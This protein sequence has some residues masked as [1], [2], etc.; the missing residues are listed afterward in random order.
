MFD[1]NDQDQVGETLW[2]KFN[3]SEDHIVPYSRDT[4]EHPI[5]SFDDCTKKQKSDTNTIARFTGQSSGAKNALSDASLENRSSHNAKED[6]SGPKIDMDQWPDLPALNNELSTG[7]LSS[8]NRSFPLAGGAVQLDGESEI[9]SNV[10]EQK[11]NDSFLDCDW[12]SIGDFDDLDRIFSN[13]S[14]FGHDMATN[15]DEFLSSSADIIGNTVLPIPMPDMPLRGDECSDHGCSSFQLVEHSGEKRKAGDKTA[16]TMEIREQAFRQTTDSNQLNEKDDRKQKLLKSRKKAEERS[17]NKASEILYGSWPQN[18]IHNQPFLCQ[19]VHPFVMSSSQV[20]P[21]PSITQPNRVGGAEP[22]EN[23]V[24]PAPFTYP[25]YGY[26]MYPYPGIPLPQHVQ[27]DR[28]GNIEHPFGPDP[29]KYANSSSMALEAQ[30]KPL[31]MSPEEKI[32]K[33]RR[34]QQAH[35][36]LAIQQQ[37]QQIGHQIFGTENS[38]S[39]ENKLQDASNTNICLEEIENKPLPSANNLLFGHEGSQCL[40]TLSNGNSVERTIYYQL[41]EA[42]KKLDI[43]ARLCIR[44]SLFR[45]ASSS[46]ERQYTSDVSNMDKS[47]E[48]KCDIPA[49][50]E[51]RGKRPMRLPDAEAYT[52]PIDRTV[53]HL[54]FHRPLESYTKPTTDEMAQSPALN[55]PGELLF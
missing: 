41:Q 1:W 12:A 38:A 46:T 35:A 3:E 30:S 20:I 11:E 13:E 24:P 44:D 17:K 5:F 53:A 21:S 42:L 55:D 2:G 14:I 54:L 9:F 10:R 4:E 6:H 31:A 32:E 25:Q 27:A 36:M 47:T 43:R 19:N 49:N 16:D 29:L 39:H 28:S 18:I 34:R 23:I 33:L 51:P 22:V 52:N 40:S 7:A 48:G 26:H 15:V 8:V 50:E 37:Q 45:L